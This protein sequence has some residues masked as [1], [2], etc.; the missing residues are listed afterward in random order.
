MGPGLSRP[1]ERPTCPR[2]KN[3]LI[4]TAFEKSF[5]KKKRVECLT[6]HETSLCA[7]VRGMRTLRGTHLILGG[8]ITER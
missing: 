1:L 7:A 4:N 5:L 6:R 3:T 2:G 8:G